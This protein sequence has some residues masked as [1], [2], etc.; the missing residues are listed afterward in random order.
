MKILHIGIFG[1]EDPACGLASAFINNS[2][3]FKAINI[4]SKYANANIIKLAK[5]FQP[6]LVFMQIQ[7]DKKIEV[8]TL[9]WLKRYGAFIINWNGDVRDTTPY[10]MVELAKYIDVTAFSNMRDVRFMRWSGF[11]SEWL[12][13]YIDTDLYRPDGEKA[14]K[15]FGKIAFFGNNTHKFPLSEFRKQMCFELKMCHGLNFALFGVNGDHNFNGNQL[16]EA[17]AYRSAKIAINVSH[18]EI[19][20]YTSDRMLRILSMGTAICLAKHYP[21]IEEVYKDGVHLKV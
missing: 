11:R 12:E 4:N 19:E 9:R 1:T 20:K 15:H 2:T 14:T 17:A 10:W 21:G 8:K 3:Q 6:D 16:G 5:Q 18:Y 13:C 7:S